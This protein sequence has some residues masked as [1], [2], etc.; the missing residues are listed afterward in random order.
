MTEPIPVRPAATVLLVRDGATGLEVF[1]VVRHHK[2]DFAS[3]ALVFPGGSVDAGDYAIA[4]DPVLCGPATRP[5]RA[6]TA[7]AGR[8]GARDIRGMRRAARAAARIGGMGRGRTRQIGAKSQGRPFGEFIVAENLELALDALT[9]F[10][11]WITPPILPKRFDTHFYIVAAPSD[12]IAIHD[13]AESVD[14]V[15]INPARALAEADA[16]KYTLVFATRLNLQM[17]AQSPDVASALAAARARRIVTVEPVAVK[18]ETRLHDAD[19]DR[20]GVRRGSV[21]GLRLGRTAHASRSSNMN[22]S[23]PPV[24]K[25]CTSATAA[26][27]SALAK[28]CWIA[29]MSLNRKVATIW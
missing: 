22:M 26:C 27:P 13:G 28:A 11:H 8:G 20:G 5:G 17:L 23:T 3:G 2:I 4:A 6:A 18:T 15:W 1:M 25:F 24:A 29:A 21:R 9:P 16:G 10:A 14:S 19:T 12:Q 7:P